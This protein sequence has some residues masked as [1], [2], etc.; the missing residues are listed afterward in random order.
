MR[1][2]EKMSVRLSDVCVLSRS[3]SSSEHIQYSVHFLDIGFLH[4]G[5]FSPL[6]DAN[7]LTPR[8]TTTQFMYFRFQTTGSKK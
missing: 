3:K 2:V 5:I 1:P 6:M 7:P 8:N 4:H